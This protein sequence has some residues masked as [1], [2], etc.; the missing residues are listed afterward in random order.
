MTTQ[1]TGTIVDEAG[2]GLKDLVV[3]IENASSLKEHEELNR[4]TTK[5]SGAFTLH[6]ANDFATGDE[7]GQQ[8]RQLRLRVLLGQHVLAEAVKADLSKL[9]SI[10]FDPIR[11]TGTE[12]TTRWA[13]L[14][15]G[16][17][18]RKTDGN[19][20]RWLADDFDA[21]GR[22]ANLMR[23]AKILDV[24]QLEILVD[25]FKPNSTEEQ[26]QIVLQFDPAIQ[27]PKDIVPRKLD[28]ADARIERLMLDASKGGVPVRIQI[29][30]WTVDIHGVLVIGTLVLIVL[31]AIFAPLFLVLMGVIA[32]SVGATIAIGNALLSR[33][34]GF[35][36][37]ELH[38]WFADA[39]SDAKLVRVRECILRSLM[40]THA[41][42]V[43]DRTREGILLGSP[44]NQDYFDTFEHVI[45][46]W[47]RGTDPSKGPIHDVSVGVRGPAVAHLEELFNSH[48]AIAAPDDVQPAPGTPMPIGDVQE[49]EVVTSVQVVRTLDRM[50]AE[51]TEGETGVLES[52]L[53]AI[54]SARRFIYIENQYFHYYRIIDALIESLKANPE[55]EL[56]LLVNVAPDMPLYPGW[57]QKAIRR[58]KDALGANAKKQV[59]I[60]TK[61]SH[62]VGDGKHTRP[63]LVDNYL[64]TKSALVDNDWASVGSAN[65]DGASLEQVE[66]ARAVL[67]G[68]VRNTESN[69]V[70]W[71]ETPTSKSPVDALRH[72]LWSEHLGLSEPNDLTLLNDAPNKKWL[73]LWNQRANDKLNQLLADS[74][75]VHKSTVLPWPDEDFER[76]CGKH[77]ATGSYLRTLFDQNKKGS[78]VKVSNFDLVPKGA[79]KFPFTY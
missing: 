8:V 22:V 46:D 60:F 53:R 76:D 47:R 38:E 57:Q 42:M 63:R 54:H 37:T 40:V 25:K 14:G 78:F 17:P 27:K 61:W 62:A 12:V 43:I 77:V 68:D 5:E 2:Q 59:G 71:E 1:A 20:V 35:K 7:P 79:P 24:M 66:Y 21:W 64:H 72:R 39:G 69:L 56:I 29:P 75:A 11:L 34:L 45:D 4:T 9:D 13:T 6:Y 51:A 48:W 55:V 18:S 50:F 49:D 41:K 73:D 16:T 3:V 67:D 36:A 44:F 23:T 28:A 19:A 10:A 26:P 58:I 70:V 65:L 31:G 32:W 30:R 33:R 74:N 15:K 52:Y